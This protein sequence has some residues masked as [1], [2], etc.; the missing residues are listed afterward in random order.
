MLTNEEDIN[1]KFL[2][3][4]KKNP[5]IVNMLGIK[6]SPD[7]TSEKTSQHVRIGSYKAV[8]G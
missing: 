5:E 2:E 4:L 1:E 8:K 6:I 3:T 7:K